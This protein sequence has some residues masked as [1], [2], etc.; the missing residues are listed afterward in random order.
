L[1][2]I[3]PDIASVLQNELFYR[4]F[5]NR[6]EIAAYCGLDPTPFASGN[7]RHEQGI[8]KAGNRRARHAAIELAWLWLHWQPD[9]ALARWFHDRVGVATGRLK[10]V[11]IVALARKL[12]I[13]L[14]RFLH[15]GTVPEGSILKA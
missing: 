4:S 10:R 6:R 13:A 14:W 1:R 12:V 9:S 11:M 15:T 3:G 7:R 5:A 8:S 2:G